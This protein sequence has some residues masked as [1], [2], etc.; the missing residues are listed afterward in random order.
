ME[1]SPPACVGNFVVSCAFAQDEI[2]SA[3]PASIETAEQIQ[4]PQK[5]VGLAIEDKSFFTDRVATAV[6]YFDTVVSCPDYRSRESDTCRVIEI[7]VVEMPDNESHKS[8][9]MLLFLPKQPGIVTLPVL[10]FNSATVEYLTEPQQIIVSEPIRSPS[11][12]LNLQAAKQKVW[13]GE[14][15]RFDLTWECSLNAG[16]LQALRPQPGLFQDPDIEVIIPRNTD[17]DTV[18]VGLPI[19]GRRVI[20][21]RRKNPDDSDA[22]GRITLPI[23]LRFSEPGVIT[24][25]ETHLEC[26]QTANA[27]NDFE[28]YARTSTTASLK[29]PTLG[30][31]STVSSL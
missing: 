2:P 12:S 21:H 6:V 13:V 28:R 7:E 8:A 22:L 27:G 4:L 26:V 20:A 25:P 10:N 24:L 1:R 9:A 14:P 31:D 16:A 15:V 30:R 29:L 17:E 3:E 19:G 11:M 5:N 18:Q 23:V